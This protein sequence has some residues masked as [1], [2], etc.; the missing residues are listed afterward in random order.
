MDSKV[1]NFEWIIS[2]DQLKPYI[3]RV[4]NESLSNSILVIGCGTSELSEQLL[5]T[6]IE[7]IL[8]VDNDEGRQP[9]IF[10]V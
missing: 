5:D 10:Y 3:K 2:Y 7:T 8:S 1:G 6:N 9:H 4:L